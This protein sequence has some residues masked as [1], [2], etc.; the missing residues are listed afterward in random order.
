VSTGSAPLE[1]VPTLAPEEAARANF[2][3]LLARLFQAPPDRALLEAL[4]SADA[5]AAETG[6]IATAWREL[7]RTAAEADPQ[8]V[9]EEYD[10]A[11]IG[12]GKAPV[13]LYAGAYS[14]RFTNETPLAELR[15]E[16]ARM[17]L[18]RRVETSEPEDHIAALCEVMRY[19]IS[20]EKAGLPVQQRFFSRW[21]WPNAEP[22]CDAISESPMTAF[23][24][25]V[26]RLAK[27]F[28]ELEKSA[29]EML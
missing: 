23:Y 9:R 24:R 16:L 5:M 6:A 25:S 11:F 14:I 17:G 3:G 2:Y 10:A 7:S 15:G 21:I 20:E 12:T 8:A 4:A 13:T 18:G 28:F 19:L 29:F 27:S 22:L 1:F 26:A